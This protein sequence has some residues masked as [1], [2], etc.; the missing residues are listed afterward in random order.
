[1]SKYIYLSNLFNVSYNSIKVF[2]P[3]KIKL[4]KIRISIIRYQNFVHILPK[5]KLRTIYYK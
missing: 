4:V 2:R 3:K 5:W 1:M